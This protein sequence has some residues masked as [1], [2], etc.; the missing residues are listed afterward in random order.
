MADFESAVKKLLV[1]EGGSKIT[2]DPTDRGGLTKFGISQK[3]YP[4]MDIKNL[5]EEQAKYLYKIDFWQKIR[6]DEIESQHIAEL[7]FEACVNMGARAGVRMAQIAAAV[8]VDGIVGRKTVDAIN[9]TSE[10]LFVAQYKLALIEYY[11][12]IVANDGTQIRF[13]LGW[14]RRVLK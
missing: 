12:D 2:N 7:I 14:I 11:A 1:K 10:A 6:G 4:S 8:T 3:S 13:L 9:S 5:T